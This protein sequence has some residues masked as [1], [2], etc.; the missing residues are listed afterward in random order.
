MRRQQL[1]EP[2]IHFL[3]RLIWL[4]TAVTPAPLHKTP[5]SFIA[6]LIPSRSSRSHPA[7]GIEPPT[8]PSMPVPVWHIKHG[9]HAHAAGHTEG[10][11]CKGPSDRRWGASGS[12]GDFELRS[13]R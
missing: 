13:E 12:A 9:P 2:E 4:K 5:L 8:R 7:A 3:F 1:R 11:R 10:S 6:G